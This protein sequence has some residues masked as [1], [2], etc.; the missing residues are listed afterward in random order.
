M[1]GTLVIV[2]LVGVP[3]VWLVWAV[4][5]VPALFISLAA[6]IRRSRH[7]VSVDARAWMHPRR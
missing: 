3:A 6:R 1:F 2:W 7:I 5:R 4:S